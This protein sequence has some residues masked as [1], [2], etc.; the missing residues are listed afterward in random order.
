MSVEGWGIIAALLLA[1]LEVV[2]IAKLLDRIGVLERQNKDL[3]QAL[4]EYYEARK[5]NR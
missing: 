4:L 2:W 1:F 3:E 5:E